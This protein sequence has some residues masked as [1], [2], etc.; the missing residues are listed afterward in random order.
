MNERC[1]V[2]PQNRRPLNQTR[3]DLLGVNY[4]EQRAK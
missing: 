4:I 3:I 2:E 1:P